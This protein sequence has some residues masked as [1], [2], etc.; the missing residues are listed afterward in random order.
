MSRPL[1]PSRIGPP[2]SFPH[3]PSI[4]GGPIPGLSVGGPPGDIPSGSIG[5]V[6][7]LLC[8]REGIL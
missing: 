5:L 4:T 8:C 1:R 7:M 3:L 6:I 2:I